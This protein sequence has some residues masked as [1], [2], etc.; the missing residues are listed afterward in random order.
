[1]TIIATNAAP[2]RTEA[3]SDGV[4]DLVAVAW[5]VYSEVQGLARLGVEVTASVSARGRITVDL[6][7]A[8]ESAGLLPGLVTQLK[9]TALTRTDTGFTIAGTSF[10]GAVNLRLTVPY[11]AITAAAA[12]ELV[13][14]VDVDLDDEV[15]GDEYTEHLA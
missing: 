10:H 5:Q 4:E 6:T 7:F 15:T 12:N 3:V 2:I 9:N 13:A 8:T 11:S 14:A 1:M